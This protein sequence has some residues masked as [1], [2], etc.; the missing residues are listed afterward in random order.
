ME[1]ACLGKKIDYGTD[2]F[3]DVWKVRK[4]EEDKNMEVGSIYLVAG[5]RRGKERF[6]EKTINVPYDWRVLSELSDCLKKL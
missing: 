4:M 2:G 1:G 3:I 6:A 5:I